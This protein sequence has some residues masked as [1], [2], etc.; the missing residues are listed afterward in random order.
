MSCITDVRLC[1][2]PCIAYCMINFST[3]VGTVMHPV[4]FQLVGIAITTGMVPPPPIPGNYNHILR[5]YQHIIDVPVLYG[6]LG[7]CNIC[8]Y[9]ELSVY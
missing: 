9:Q 7:Q 4:K 2:G 3:F 8:V 5:Q 6:L 1:V